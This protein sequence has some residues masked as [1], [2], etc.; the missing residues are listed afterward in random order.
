MD[1]TDRTDRQVV[2]WRKGEKVN[3]DGEMKSDKRGKMLMS[4]ETVKGGQK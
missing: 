2:Q 3:G 4:D 1:S